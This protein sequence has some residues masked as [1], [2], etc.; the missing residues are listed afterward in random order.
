MQRARAC[1]A[2]ERAIDCVLLVEAT[3][4]T[5]R[6]VVS[7]LQLVD[8]QTAAVEESGKAFLCQS[9]SDE[10]CTLL[11]ITITARAVRTACQHLVSTKRRFLWIYKHEI[12][13]ISVPVHQV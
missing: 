3:A 4:A 10:H 13:L 5:H 12:Y 8:L 9:F 7:I 2:S 11:L 1:A 6:R